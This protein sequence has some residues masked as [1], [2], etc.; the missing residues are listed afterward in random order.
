[1]KKSPPFQF[2]QFSIAHDKCAMKVNTDGILLGAL[3]EV[4]NVKRILDLGTGSGLVALMLAQRSSLDCQ[5]TALE[6][7]PNAYQQAVE[8][9]KNSAW[10]DRLHFVQGDVMQTAFK[11]KFDLIVSNPPYFQDSLATRNKQRDLA[12]TALQSHLEWLNQAQKWLADE[13]KITMILPFEAGEKLIAQTELYCV[14]RWEISTKQNQPPKRM[15]VSFSR[16]FAN[17]QQKQLSIYTLENS[18]T[19]EFKVLTQAFYLK[20]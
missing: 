12:R 19:E 17:L 6:I 15:V 9:G 3:A 7:E 8:N 4:E 14:K 18:Y 10:A 2:K 5:I 16:H 11:E 1:M 13:G 20:M